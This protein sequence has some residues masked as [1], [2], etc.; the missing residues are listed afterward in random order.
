MTRHRSLLASALIGE[1]YPIL[2]DAETVIADPIVRNRGTIGGSLC[3]ADPAED[4]SAVA[5]ALRAERDPAIR[6]RIA[7]RPGP[8]IHRRSVRHRAG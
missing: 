3:Q 2:H 1:H 4:L 8:R 6:R 7:D 5:A